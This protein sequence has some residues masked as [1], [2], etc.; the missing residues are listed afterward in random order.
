MKKFVFSFLLIINLIVPL[1]QNAKAA[2]KCLS[3]FADGDWANGTPVGVKSQIGFELIEKVEDNGVPRQSLYSTQDQDCWGPKDR[4][5]VWKL[6]K[7]YPQV[8]CQGS[9]P[10]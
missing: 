9:L 5:L 2:D 8:L 3:S 7:I 1:S 4:R 6:D 10:E